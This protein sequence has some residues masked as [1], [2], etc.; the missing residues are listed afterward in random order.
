[1]D[2]SRTTLRIAAVGDL[3]VSVRSES[4]VSLWHSISD[5]ADVLV[6]CGDLTDLGQIPE[7]EKL[8]RDLKTVTLPI[9]AVLGNHDFEAGAQTEVGQMLADVGVRVLDGEA[10]EVLGVGFAGVKGFIGGFGRQALAPWGERTIKGLVQEGLEES[11]KLDASLAKLRTATRIAVLHYAPIAETVIGEP[12]EIFPF[13]GS[14]HLEDPINRHEVAAV[15]HGHAHRGS[16]EGKT[17]TGIPVLNVSLPL[18]KALHPERPPFRLYE[19]DLRGADQAGDGK[20]MVGT[21]SS[22]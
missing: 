8:A 14:S 4:L 17:K 22:V 16:S 6:L 5:A 21:A 10:C 19:V 12:P 13:L 7:A 3:H 9:V 11:L 18:L 1:M 20:T 15:F 2:H